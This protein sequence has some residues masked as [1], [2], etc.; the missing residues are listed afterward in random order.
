[1]GKDYV[2]HVLATATR[3]KDKLVLPS[4]SPAYKGFRVLGRRPGLF[5]EALSTLQRTTGASKSVDVVCEGIV[6]AYCFS[7]I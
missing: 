1:L 3:P 4:V 2:Q 6:N 5:E 7:H